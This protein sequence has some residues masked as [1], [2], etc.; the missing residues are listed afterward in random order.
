MVC[1]KMNHLTAVGLGLGA[2]PS[3][4]EE[5]EKDVECVNCR[6][7]GSCFLDTIMGW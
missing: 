6:Q 7:G 1:I 3:A 4:V 5:V 2:M